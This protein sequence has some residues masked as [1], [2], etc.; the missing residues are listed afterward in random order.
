MSTSVINAIGPEGRDHGLEPERT[1]IIRL[2]TCIIVSQTANS[3]VE[4]AMEK[5]IEEILQNQL[6]LLLNKKSSLLRSN[7]ISLFQDVY[8]DPLDDFQGS[9][10]FTTIAMSPLEFHVI[11]AKPANYN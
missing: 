10:Q 6:K 4:P 1:L 5:V 2:S 7:L 8:G 3:V 9:W 11:F